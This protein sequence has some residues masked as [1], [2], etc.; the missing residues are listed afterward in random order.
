VPGQASHREADSRPEAITVGNRRRARSSPYARGSL[1]VDSR[2]TLAIY[3]LQPGS[4][5]LRSKT[6]SSMARLAGLLQHVEIHGPIVLST[7][8]VFPQPLHHAD[9][10][11]SA[12]LQG[13]LSRSAAA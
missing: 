1:I 3:G 6:A 5:S 4:G 12:R 10:L 13:E 8:L 11:A 7:I 9:S 2:S